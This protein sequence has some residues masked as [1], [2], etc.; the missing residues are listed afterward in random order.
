MSRIWDLMRAVETQ[1]GANRGIPETTEPIRERRCAP[2]SWTFSPVLVY[3]YMADNE[4][5]HEGT[6]ALHVNAGG[7][8]ITLTSGVV[9]GQT[10]ILINKRNEK[11]EKCRVVCR[12]SGYLH[13]A[14]VAV[15]FLELS[16]DFWS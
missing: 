9:E 12:R 15:K 6:E 4:P 14:A 13:R 1:A 11:E 16:P 7:G 3:G 10:L 8:L 5:F 2:R